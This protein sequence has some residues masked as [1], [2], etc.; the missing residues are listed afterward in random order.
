MFI[1]I[2]KTLVS[3]PELLKY[4]AESKVI[5]YIIYIILSFVFSFRKQWFMTPLITR[6]R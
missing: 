1:K 2:K 4:E 3:R 5:I 6:Q